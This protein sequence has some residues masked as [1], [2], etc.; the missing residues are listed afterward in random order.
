MS[1]NVNAPFFAPGARFHSI[2]EKYVCIIQDNEG[3]EKKAL[4]KAQLIRALMTKDKLQPHQAESM[5]KNIRHN[6]VD[7]KFKPEHIL[8]EVH[9]A[10][11][12]LPA[13]NSRAATIH[14]LC[15]MKTGEELNIKGKDYVVIRTLTPSSTRPGLSTRCVLFLSSNPSCNEEDARLFI[16]ETT[17][18]FIS[19]SQQANN[20]PMDLTPN[21]IQMYI[22]PLGNA[23]YQPDPSTIASTLQRGQIM[24]FCKPNDQ[25]PGGVKVSEGKWKQ[26]PTDKKTTDS[27]EKSAVADTSDQIALTEHIRTE[28]Q[29]ARATLKSSESSWQNR[30]G[31]GPTVFASIEARL[32][33]LSR[34]M[35]S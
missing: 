8:P 19:F 18:T 13:R 26:M 2:Q 24:P 16:N 35:K 20:C 25:S 34:I 12:I 5:I 30:V 23:D 11:E 27:R 6:N 7:L 32:A 4:S 14:D 1:L 3:S 15:N 33:F 17:G 31:S 22:K 10:R 9:L 29:L 21:E 28:Q